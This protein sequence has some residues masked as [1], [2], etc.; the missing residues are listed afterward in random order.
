MFCSPGEETCLGFQC[1][2]SRVFSL[3]RKLGAHWITAR[4]TAILF[5]AY[6]FFK[7]TKYGEMCMYCK[8]TAY[9][10]FPD[11]HFEYMTLLLLLTQ[12]EV[13]VQIDL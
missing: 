10:F 8:R 1:S 6:S 2:R 9:V 4:S 11:I 12:K 13:P 7:W 5:C 3:N